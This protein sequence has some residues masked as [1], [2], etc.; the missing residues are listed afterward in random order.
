METLYEQ[1]I[2]LVNWLNEQCPSV[3][4]PLEPYDNSDLSHNF[5]ELLR[6]R[7]DEIDRL[8]KDY[9]P[10]KASAEE[11]G[12]KYG[13]INGFTIHS[14]PF[15]AKE[16]FN[17]AMHEFALQSREIPSEEEIENWITNE[18]PVNVDDINDEET[19]KYCRKAVRLFYEWLKSKLG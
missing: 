1:M 4:T 15:I 8:R 13:I 11:I 14:N 3:A 6:I 10:A 7:L 9:T 2:E 18:I 19:S 5:T 16:N 12:K 17:K